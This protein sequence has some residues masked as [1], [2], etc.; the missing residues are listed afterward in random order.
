MLRD[1][2][3]LVRSDKSSADDIRLLGRFLSQSLTNP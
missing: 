3:L 2:W 1:S